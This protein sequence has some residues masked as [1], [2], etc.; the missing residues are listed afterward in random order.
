MIRTLRL[1]AAILIALGTAGLG[2]NSASATGSQVPFRASYSGAAAFTSETSVAFNGTG[3][4]SL[5]GRGT[6]AGGAQFTD[7]VPNAGCFGGV[8]F[9]NVHTETLTSADGDSLTITAHDIA[10][11][12]SE[13]RFRGTGVW[14]VTGGTGRFS[15]ATGEGTLEGQAD[16]TRGWDQGEFSFQLAGTISAPAGG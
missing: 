13:Y 14:E 1:L 16:F 12:T 10:C 9:P 5:L 4:A 2:T 15:G 8:E 7:Q 3:V 6:N 11:P